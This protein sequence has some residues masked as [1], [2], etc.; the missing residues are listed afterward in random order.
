M[1]RFAYGICYDWECNWN[2][3]FLSQIFIRTWIIIQFCWMWNQTSSGPHVFKIT[4]CFSTLL[5]WPWI[6]FGKPYTDLS[7]LKYYIDFQSQAHACRHY[8]Y[9]FGLRVLRILPS[10]QETGRK[11]FPEPPSDFD[12]LE[13]YKQM[14]FED[15][16]EDADIEPVIR[17]LKGNKSLRIPQMWKECLFG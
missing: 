10:L 14:A 11:E 7:T 12:P 16:W 8:P 1:Y 13:C 3:V 6:S 5:W 15:L 9:R 2:L 17:Y 4:T